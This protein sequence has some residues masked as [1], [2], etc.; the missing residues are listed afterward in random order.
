MGTQ[1]KG[2]ELIQAQALRALGILYDSTHDDGS[3]SAPAPAS[4]V[5]TAGGSSEDKDKEGD[6]NFP[7][8]PSRLQIALSRPTKTTKTTTR[9]HNSRR[10]ALTIPTPPLLS[11]CL[12]DDSEIVRLTTL[13]S[14][15]PAEDR[16]SVV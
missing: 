1:D 11:S 9:R 16:K 5:F 2:D 7:P 8:L 6:S 13:Q 12:M 3:S 4:G 15:E 14:P 10:Q